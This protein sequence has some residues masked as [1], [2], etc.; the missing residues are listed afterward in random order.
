MGCLASDL[1]GSVASPLNLSRPVMRGRCQGTH[2][3]AKCRRQPVCSRCSGH[4][5]ALA[6]R[7]GSGSPLLT[8]AVVGTFNTWPHLC[9]RGQRGESTPF[10]GLYEH[11]AF[12]RSNGPGSSRPPLLLGHDFQDGTVFVLPDQAGQHPGVQQTRATVTAS[13]EH[14]S[15]TATHRR[16]APM[17]IRSPVPST[18]VGA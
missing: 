14:A 4:R 9:T 6:L 8:L 7:N 12:D 17:L 11:I 16:N 5:G 13:T 15:S 1:S 18:G 10:I 3:A 2:S